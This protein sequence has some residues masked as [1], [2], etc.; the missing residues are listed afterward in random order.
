MVAGDV[1]E[2]KK[3]DLLMRN[4]DQKSCEGVLNV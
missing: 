4:G 3:M 2:V 1:D